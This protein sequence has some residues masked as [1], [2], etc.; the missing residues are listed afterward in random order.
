MVAHRSARNWRELRPALEALSWGDGLTREEMLNQSR[1]LRHPAIRQLP[2]DFRFKNASSVLS[3]FEQ[4][5]ATGP[6]DVAAFP[7][8]SGYPPTSTTGITVAGHALNPG[9]G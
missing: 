9:V 2:P 8:P 3:Y 6:M 4:V 7:P 1:A 5:E